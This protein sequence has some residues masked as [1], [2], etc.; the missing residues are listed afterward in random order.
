MAGNQDAF[1][2]TDSP[3]RTPQVAMAGN[4]DALQL[5]GTTSVYVIGEEEGGSGET[6]PRTFHTLQDHSAE[7]SAKADRAIAE[8]SAKAERIRVG[9]NRARAESD[10]AVARERLLLRQQLA[11]LTN[12]PYPVDTPTKIK[13]KH[14]KNDTQP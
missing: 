6:D 8:A 4:K 12:Q 9:A 5:R 11:A 10:R 1:E 13:P 7:A 14:G 3:K 2:L